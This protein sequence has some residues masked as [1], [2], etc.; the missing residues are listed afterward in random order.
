MVFTFKDPVTLTF[1]LLTP[2]TDGS[3]D[4]VRTSMLCP[5]KVMGQTELMEQKVFIPTQ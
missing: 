3:F 4:S 1:D 5:L 2:K